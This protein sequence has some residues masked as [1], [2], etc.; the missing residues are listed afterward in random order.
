MHIHNMEA[1]IQ[2]VSVCSRMFEIETCEIKKAEF[3]GV[4]EHFFDKRDEEI[5]HYGQTLEESVHKVVK[6]DLRTRINH[7]GWPSNVVSDFR[8]QICKYF[9]NQKSLILNQKTPT[10]K[11]GLNSFIF[12][13]FTDLYPYKFKLAQCG[14]TLR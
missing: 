2:K 13:L 4:N 8:F 1:S 5:G 14:I 9:A 6:T 10:L 12:S 11:T 3:A 7:V